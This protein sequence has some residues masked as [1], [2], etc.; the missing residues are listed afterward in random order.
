LKEFADKLVEKDAVIEELKT[1]K[2]NV[3]KPI[4]PEV[5]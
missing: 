3:E 5:Q 2:K 1:F 4:L